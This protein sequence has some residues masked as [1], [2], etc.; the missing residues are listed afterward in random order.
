MIPM[1]TMSALRVYYCPAILAVVRENYDSR[2]EEN[3]EILICVLSV[4]LFPDP[5]AL[6]RAGR[7]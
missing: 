6:A 3:T 4:F 2:P 1:F 7:P 5:Q